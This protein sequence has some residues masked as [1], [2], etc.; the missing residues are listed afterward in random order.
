M[1]AAI[2]G[3]LCKLMPISDGNGLPIQSRFPSLLAREQAN[4]GGLLA[5]AQASAAREMARPTRRLY[6]V[7]DTEVRGF[8]IR[9]MPS[10]RK[11][12][13]SG[14]AIQ[15]RSSLRGVRWGD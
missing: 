15:V 2:A 6:E 7:M 5:R 12:S 4:A 14:G 11:A 3:K 13:F 8:G 9:V 10:G 1:T